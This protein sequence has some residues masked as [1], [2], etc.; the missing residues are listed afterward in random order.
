[1]CF[2]IRNLLFL[3]TVYSCLAL[4][5]HTKC[6]RS[7][8]IVFVCLM[9]IMMK[10]SL[11]VYIGIYNIIRGRNSNHVFLVRMFDIAARKRVCA[12]YKKTMSICNVAFSLL[13]AIYRNSAMAILKCIYA[14]FIYIFVS[15][16]CCICE[17]NT[18]KKLYYFSYI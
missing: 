15:L 4:M 3:H 10:W 6:R 5:I 9:M 14:H 12:M 2:I 7:R 16:C 13:F 8:E 17:H 18:G 11:Y 1:M